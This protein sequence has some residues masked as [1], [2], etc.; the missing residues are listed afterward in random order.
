MKF[1]DYNFV[2][3]ETAKRIM[4]S[5]GYDVSEKE[6]IVE[7][8]TEEEL[9]Q[10]IEEDSTDSET[11][12]E[13]E[14]PLCVIERE[15]DFYALCEDIETVDSEYY[16]PVIAIPSEEA[17]KLDESNSMLMESVEFEE[18]TF[19]LGDIF[20]DENSSELFVALSK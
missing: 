18:E 16:I 17:Q 4:E 7:E 13:E 15:G 20:E 3:D 1:V 19:N 9:D 6:E 5:Y 14:G 2:D 10:V 8:I 11:L 12:S